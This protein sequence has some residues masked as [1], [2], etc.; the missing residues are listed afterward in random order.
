MW[1][2]Q[3]TELLLSFKRLKSNDC[4]KHTFD[5]KRCQEY[6]DSIPPNYVIKYI[7]L[8]GKF[9]PTHPDN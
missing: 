6:I 5:S 8:S 4:L 7:N 1:A 3:K 9:T 2:D